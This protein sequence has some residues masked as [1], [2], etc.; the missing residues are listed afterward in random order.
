MLVFALLL[1]GATQIG[2]TF[3]GGLPLGCALSLGSLSAF[4]RALLLFR[5][6]TVLLLKSALTRSSSL[7]LRGTMLFCCPAASGL[8]SARRSR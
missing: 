3:L 1:H 5:S 7:L 2:S 6:A 8:I 4:I